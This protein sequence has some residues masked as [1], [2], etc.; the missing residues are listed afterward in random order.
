MT[1]R[2]ILLHVLASVFLAACVGDR[3]DDSAANRPLRLDFGNAIRHNEALQIIDPRPPAAD[4]Q[5]PALD[6]KR[7]A[8]AMARYQNGTVRKLEIERTGDSNAE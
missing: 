5:A 4:E 6:G 7:A 8:A 1:G 3:T 2:L